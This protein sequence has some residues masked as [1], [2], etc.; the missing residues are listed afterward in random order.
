MS[1]F[2]D[3]IK[4]HGKGLDAAEITELYRRVGKSKDPGS[5]AAGVLAID[6]H[7]NELNKDRSI[8][9][10]QLKNYFNAG[11]KGTVEDLAQGTP[12]AEWRPGTEVTQSPMDR[13]KV[14][15][16]GA[17][18]RFKRDRED[19]TEPTPRPPTDTT[20]NEQEESI[21]PIGETPEQATTLTPD[22]YKLLQNKLK[23]TSHKGART[24]K[25]IDKMVA[26]VI[27]A[28]QTGKDLSPD[29]A[30]SMIRQELYKMGVLTELSVESTPVAEEKKA[31]EPVAQAEPVQG[32]QIFRQ[33]N[34]DGKW[35]SFDE[36]YAS[37]FGKTGKPIQKQ[38]LPDN[39]KLIDEPDF[40]LLPNETIDQGLERL[41]YD[42]MT[43][44]EEQ[45][46]GPNI[47]SVYLAKPEAPDVGEKK[48]T[49]E[50]MAAAMDKFFSGD[51]KLTPDK[52]KDLES[53]KDM[54]EDAIATWKANGKQPNQAHIEKLAKVKDQLAEKQTSDEG[55]V[56]DAVF[57][58]PQG[59]FAPGF[60][61]LV[62]IRVK[63]REQVEKF[64][65]KAQVIL[66][67]LQTKISKAEAI[68]TGR[69]KTTPKEKKEAKAYMASMT[70]TEDTLN[71]DRIRN[72]TMKELNRLHK[73]LPESKPP[74]VGGKATD[75]IF[76]RPLTKA[77]DKS[78]SKFRDGYNTIPEKEGYD[79]VYKPY[80]TDGKGYYY[81]K[82]VT[83]TKEE[84]A[85]AIDKFFA[86]DKPKDKPINYKKIADDLFSAALKKGWKEGG[87]D[88]PRVDQKTIDRI[89][90]KH[91]TTRFD[92]L[93]GLSP[94]ISVREM[95]V[96][97][98]SEKAYWL[99]RKEPVVK[100][101]L[102]TEKPVE[103]EKKE[104]T[105]TV[106]KAWTGNKWQ[107]I[108]NAK[109]ITRKSKRQGQ[110]QVTLPDGKKI[111]VP[112]EKLKLDGEK[113]VEPEVTKTKEGVKVEAPKAPKQEG[114]TLK[115]Q[116]AYL[117]DE[118][119]KAIRKAPEN[120]SEPFKYQ[121]GFIDRRNGAVRIV[122][123][124]IEELSKAKFNAKLLKD[125]KAIS[126][127]ETRITELEDN[128]KSLREDLE[129]VDQEGREAYTEYLN[130][131]G[132]SVLIK[133]PGGA[134]YRI[135]ND[136]TS[137]Q[138]FK[139]NANKYPA[140]E[141]KAPEAKAPTVPQPVASNKGDLGPLL[142][143]KQKGWFTDGHVL[144][145]GDAPAKAKLDDGFKEDNR[146]ISQV[147][148]KSDD[149]LEDADRSYYALDSDYLQAQSVS[150]EPIADLYVNE[151]KGSKL[152]P[153]PVVV[154]ESKSGTK[155]AFDQG[156]FNFIRNRF[157]NATYKLGNEGRTLY[158]YDKG[159]LVG[160]IMAK[161][162]ED[163]FFSKMEDFRDV[164]FS[165][166]TVSNP[167]GQPV[168]MGNAIANKFKPIFKGIKNTQIVVLPS[169]T[170][171]G[172]DS[173]KNFK[174]GPN[175][176]V[177]GLFAI[178]PETGQRTIFLIMDAMNSEK[179]IISTLLEEIAHNGI[180]NILTKEQLVSIYDEFKDDPKMLAILKAYKKIDVSTEE[181]KANASDEFIAK[182]IKD[183]LLPKSIWA[184]IV[185]AIRNLFRKAKIDVHYSVE[186]IKAL[187]KANVLGTTSSPA[188]GTKQG[189]REM[190]AFH[191]TPHI[192]TPEKGF[193]N[194]RPRLDKIFSKE[195]IGE[196][197]W[198][199][200]A[201][202]YSA[203]EQGTAELYKEM[204]D[205]SDLLP[206]DD[207]DFNDT[208]YEIEIG[209]MSGG[210]R[211]FSDGSK[212]S[213]SHKYWAG[214]NE[215]SSKKYFKIYDEYRKSKEASL[216][217]LDIPD[218][219]IPQLLDWDAPLSEQTEYVK[220][221]LKPLIDFWKGQ[222][223]TDSA[224]DSWRGEQVYERASFVGAKNG[225]QGDSRD[226]VASKYLA[227]IGIPGNV[228]GG[229]SK[230]ATGLKYVIWDQ[231]VLDKIALLERNQ[232]PLKAMQEEAEA[233]AWVRKSVAETAKFD[234]FFGENIGG[235][236]QSVGKW[237]STGKTGFKAEAPDL[238]V[239]DVA[240]GTP[241]FTYD[242]VPALKRI[243]EYAT[244]YSKDLYN[245]IDHL[246][247]KADKSYIPTNLSKLMKKG[248]GQQ[249]QA[250]SLEKYLFDND[251]NQYGFTK[252]ETDTGFD[253]YDPQKK[254]VESIPFVT[255]PESTADT[256]D[257]DPKA[258]TE[259]LV[260]RRI[261][262]LEVKE[263]AANH[264]DAGPDI[265]QAL[266]DVRGLT[267]RSFDMLIKDLREII[268]QH[269]EAGLP[270]PV[271][272]VKVDG[273]DI[274]VDM[275][276]ALALMGDRRGY[277]MP[278]MR[279]PGKWVLR[280][281]KEGTPPYLEFFDVK[282][283][284]PI[285]GVVSNISGINKRQRELE[286]E[287][288]KV[289]KSRS[290]KIGEDTWA[291]PAQVIKMQA[292]IN[293]ALDASKD[294]IEQFGLESVTRGNDLVISGEYNAAIKKVMEAKGGVF[295]DSTEP[296][297]ASW[298]F[299]NKETGYEKEIVKALKKNAPMAGFDTMIR[300]TQTRA[301]M[302]SIA[303]VLHSRGGKAHMIGR[304]EAV[305][306]EVTRGYIEKMDVALA[307]YAKGL[308]ASDAKRRMVVGQ[309]EAFNGTDIKWAEFK[310]TYKTE[311]GED[312]TYEQY[313][314]SVKDRRVQPNTNAYKDGLGYIQNMARNQ[315]TLD[316]VIGMVNGVV[317]LKFLAF[318]AAAP[319]VNLTAMATSVPANMSAKTGVSLTRAVMLSANMMK[320]YGQ[321]RWSKDVMKGKVKVPKDV[322]DLFEEIQRNGWDQAQFNRE[323]LSV[324]K[325]KVGNV[326]EGLIEKG[327]LGFAITEQINRVATIAG[328]Y[329]AIKEQAAKT[330]KAFDHKKA[331]ELAKEVSDRSHG[332]YTKANKPTITRG[333]GALPKV[334]AAFYMFKTF[335][336]TYLQAM[337]S[338]WG[339][340][341]K[342]KH[343][344]QFLYM[345]MSPA[346]IAGTGAMALKPVLDPVIGMIARAFFDSDDPEE[347][348]YKWLEQNV[349]D[350]AETM[351]RYGM[352]GAIPEAVGLPGVSFKGSM[353]IGFDQIPTSIGDFLGA[354][355]SMIKDTFYEGPKELLKGNF[356]KGFEKTVPSN[357]VASV[358]K[359]IR[360]GT[361]GVTT[362]RG[363]PLFY[364]PDPVK[365]GMME[366]IFRA[367][368][369]N[370][371]RIATIREKMWSETVVET[372]YKDN[373]KDINDKI[374][375]FYIDPP[376]DRTA[377][378]WIDILAEIR[379]YN[380]R[381]M[382][383]GLTGIVPFVTST[384]IKNNLKRNFTPTK[385]EML[386]RAS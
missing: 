50:E 128:L 84:M 127:A 7:R 63:S 242:K 101:A 257:A 364:G 341:L 76:I 67:K 166:P 239:V 308:A 369:F 88:T 224:L 3:C 218:D 240:L 252:K 265:L 64:M 13:F 171:L 299:A 8:I 348:W 107:Y 251:R 151:G 236:W 357:A 167:K 154:F 94:D 1:K 124:S 47:T 147:L 4:I 313:R 87:F 268:R 204:F 259:T 203:K 33:G 305:G 79:A 99:T 278:R 270:L 377:A 248:S 144:I 324:L 359:G 137:L 241:S 289:E 18:A 233:D 145:K 269:E 168:K 340:Q 285:S 255:T 178:N 122:N 352:M 57:G 65:D 350:T 36:D 138:E 132:N 38:T 198:T 19:V 61:N 339:W 16:A 209:T 162:M 58:H 66:D 5:I 32:R 215:I 321:Y 200:G 247:R 78:N 89:A 250:I 323:S 143:I 326:F 210:I 109:E 183:D 191:A 102:T 15:T 28:V 365:A 2:D 282:G 6:E 345:A 22:Q 120:R 266:A 186:E 152:A 213:K 134:E 11:S 238:S 121:E 187:V 306:E 161:R 180:S 133:V 249:K 298:L 274:K 95:N 129:A 115:E 82:K 319:L 158:T 283:A 232:E 226:Q 27:D 331:L 70:H 201:G 194:G 351:A 273:E 325:S 368:S 309:T 287:G 260:H 206:E 320:E 304:S 113:P 225:I 142:G 85:G 214:D 300:E 366:S 199:Y 267:G 148:P 106:G 244:G 156:K 216:Y 277:Y 48:Q 12:Q 317:V 205:E 212:S 291:L 45:M 316:R 384:S 286:A 227:S 140:S 360:E 68:A 149:A 356:M 176:L 338:L 92:L 74:D 56:S 116:K 136:K 237:M 343:G 159:D 100:K 30:K 80:G 361:E 71:R 362:R 17:E 97:G 139:K 188:V 175:E 39:I 98:S 10:R 344:K 157:P 302:E 383:R 40:K 77:E 234:T 310:D 104:T 293:K 211:T 223:A 342:P 55:I 380:E 292:V 373:R 103:P 349:G 229:V 185:A 96:P 220:K 307:L 279:Q 375:K 243:Y 146:D 59:D 130:Q 37:S 69:M 374:Y 173:L 329:M 181:G 281:T 254:F 177:K 190:V 192:W 53:L 163:D 276:K 189:V 72:E 155:G 86:G 193:P 262:E 60:E 184:K 363:T 196:G 46:T 165:K 108:T 228:H 322:V 49:K 35:W 358:I 117:A 41:G 327:M 381:V 263:Y 111:Y 264:P 353:E 336:H 160:L 195:T 382:R 126:N 172:S 222:G 207:F 271:R 51:V 54:L 44:M 378:R 93:T 355:G 123:E 376:E 208:K 370:P 303:N 275:K 231:S 346:V 179:D 164:R 20:I 52:R 311:N 31:D 62:P 23:R 105:Q 354:P 221:A 119:N 245:N 312:P 272:S 253:I 43:R 371:T 135:L 91:G 24:P 182:S 314:E 386:K 295:Q 235:I 174:I 246:L 112:K 153:R 385:R 90:K 73:L 197:N 296:F 110:F 256:I 81:V 294:S 261:T 367:F 75:E 26:E 25:V 202:W 34:K 21:Q 280:A 131:P 284:N 125:K 301:L 332:D 334:G 328:S 288:Y 170:N 42:G 219:V 217:K 330:G 9:A 169:K 29:S 372:R 335:S 258:A 14:K 318:R 337:A 333:S 315:E 379:E 114:A 150:T 83:Q 347:D 230:G 141:L 297:K 118:I 290:T